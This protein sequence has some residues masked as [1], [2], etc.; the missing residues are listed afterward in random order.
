LL[1]R[2][3]LAAGLLGGRGLVFAVVVLGCVL[4]P[5][6][7]TSLLGRRSGL[8]LT[9][10]FF[11]GDL[12][13][14]WPTTL[15]RGGSWRILLLFI[16]DLLGFGTAL[17]WGWRRRVLFVFVFYGVLLALGCG[18]LLRFLVRFI[19]VLVVSLLG[20]LRSRLLSAWSV[21]FNILGLMMSVKLNLSISL[22]WCEDTYM[23]AVCIWDV[24]VL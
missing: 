22:R 16:L 12:F 17:L 10:V 23:R 18:L 8:F 24:A 21:I 1:G 19:A 20:F 9:A 11:L 5:A 6:A 13:L 14:G 7:G 2:S 3:L 4:G 15:L